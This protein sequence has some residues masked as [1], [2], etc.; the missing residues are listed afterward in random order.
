[1]GEASASQGPVSAPIWDRGSFR[2]LATAPEE[3]RP[4]VLFDGQAMLSRA[5]GSRKKSD[6]SALLGRCSRN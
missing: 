6:D 2:A 1:M 4:P 5:P 3:R